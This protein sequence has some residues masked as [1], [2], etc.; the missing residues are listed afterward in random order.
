MIAIPI[1]RYSGK[2]LYEL[3]GS[4]LL[5]YLSQGFFCEKYRRHWNAIGKEV[6]RRSITMI[7]VE[8]AIKQDSEAI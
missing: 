6:E 4:C 5:W 3:D 8:I 7:L 2:D 1:G